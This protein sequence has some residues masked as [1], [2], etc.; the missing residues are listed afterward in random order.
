MYI[1]RNLD[2][3]SNVEKLDNITFDGST[4]YALT[5]NSTAFVPNSAQCILISINGIVQ[6]GNFSVNSSNI[7]F[8]SAV[9][10]SDVCNWVL[11]Y[12]T[13]LI[14]TVA[15]GTI[16][17]DKL[18][19][20]AVTTAKI[21]A[22]AVDGTKIADDS[23]SDEHLDIT[24]I[25]GHSEKT[26]LV[27]ADKFLISDSAASGALKYVQ[28]SNLPSGGLVYLGGQST[29]TNAGGYYIDNVM[30][31][32]YTNYKIV[33]VMMQDNTSSSIFSKL[34]SWDGSSGG[35][36]SSS[37]NIQATTSSANNAS[38]GTSPVGSGA[39]AVHWNDT[40]FTVA[41]DPYN[42]RNTNQYGVI[43]DYTLYRPASSNAYLAAPYLVGQVGF[44]EYNGGTPRFRVYSTTITYN[45]TVTNLGGISFF[46]NS[47]NMSMIDISVYGMVGS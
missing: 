43:V 38:G 35:N 47:G 32:T 13:G 26:S 40:K 16:T 17:A 42:D 22:D 23:I 39:A 18:G 9:S 36:L 46:A 25:T 1:G 30:S 19:S 28:K 41:K 20:S 27:D 14:T 4:S 2:S 33:G 34:R 7:V 24:A 3:I 29:H 44:Y 37:Y 31:D 10:S 15:D 8:D 45:Q 6:Q 21:N 5:K 11:H 12:G